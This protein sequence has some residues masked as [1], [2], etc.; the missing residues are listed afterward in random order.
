MYRRK[1]RHSRVKN[2]YKFASF[3]TASAHTVESSLELDAC[4]HLE[5]SPQVK[6]F[7]APPQTVRAL[8]RKHPHGNGNEDAFFK[9]RRSPK[10]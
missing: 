3:K 8:D 6:S 7:I 9:T 10:A 1:L 4:Y 5:Y 2:L